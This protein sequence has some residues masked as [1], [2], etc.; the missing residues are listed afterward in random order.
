MPERTSQVQWRP[1]ALE[2]VP[3]IADRC[4]PLFSK[5]FP[6]Q[7]KLVKGT[8]QRE[9]ECF[10][11]VYPK[12]PNFPGT[13]KPLEPSGDTQEIHAYGV[14]IWSK[15]QVSGNQTDNCWCTEHTPHCLHLNFLNGGGRWAPLNTPSVPHPPTNRKDNR[16]WNA[17]HDFICFVIAIP[18]EKSV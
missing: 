5:R 3:V 15:E 4:I 8:A 14:Q 10:F 16:I 11:S 2:R 17:P 13:P 6:K 1:G 7:T 9:S 12:Y 18:S